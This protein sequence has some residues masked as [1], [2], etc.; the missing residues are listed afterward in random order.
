VLTTLILLF[1][2]YLAGAL[3]AGVGLPRLKLRATRLERPG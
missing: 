2:S 3:V 1:L